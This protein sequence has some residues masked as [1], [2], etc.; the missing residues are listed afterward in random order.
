MDYTYLP[1]L[2]NSFKLYLSNAPDIESLPGN[3]SDFT[4][5]Q[6]INLQPL[7]FLKS[8]DS[9]LCV[10]DLIINQIATC[11]TTADKI[12]VQCSL[13]TDSITPNLTQNKPAIEEINNEKFTINLNEV[14]ATSPAV[15]IDY[16]NDK[17]SNVRLF[18][19]QRLS[20]VFFD[21]TIF[22]QDSFQSLHRDNQ[23]AISL[24]EVNLLRRYIDAVTLARV[25][26]HKFLTPLINDPN[27][28][29]LPQI[30]FSN[31]KPLLGES[32]EREILEKSSILLNLNERATLAKTHFLEI[33]KFQDY[34]Q[35]DYAKK[36]SAKLEIVR[37][38]LIENFT[39]YLNLLN[40]NLDELNDGD[41]QFLT[42]CMRDNL[43]LIQAGQKI[44]QILSLQISDV[45][46]SLFHQQPITVSIE[47]Y[48]GRAKL[49]LNYQ[50]FFSEDMIISLKATLSA[51]VA[52]SLGAETDNK[53]IT[54]ENSGEIL[55]FPVRYHPRLIHIACDIVSISESKD[56]WLINSQ[57]ENLSVIHSQTME[58]Q[59]LENRFITK[60]DST[61]KQLKLVRNAKLIE[62]IRFVILDE[63]GRKINFPERTIVRLGLE[64]SAMHENI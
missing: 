6:D 42:S 33:F 2:R 18:L 28:P 34:F 57:Y 25:E 44:N 43:T 11:V 36:S 56:F 39:T 59:S 50:P 21:K 37:R 53:E 8:T 48:S 63:N 15:L 16:L 54:I 26:F 23:L 9:Q 12:V 45:P 31:V 14:T 64:I 58:N 24:D 55:P 10:T 40:M 41:I 47:K 49:S 7:T 46:A 17:L 22:K 3:A 19:V 61:L 52:Y 1:T 62:K 13:N 20:L 30:S 27:A 51:N 60:P 5:Y 32:L 35:L 38:K 29:K 4:T